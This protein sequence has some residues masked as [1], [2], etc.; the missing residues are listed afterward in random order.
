MTLD[1]LG[2]WASGGTPSRAVSAY[3]HGEI[4]WVKIGDLNDGVITRTAE[5]ITDSGLAASSARL[6]PPNVL[7]V[8]M[9]GASIGKLGVTGINCSTNQ[10]IASCVP[11]PDVVDLW[12]LY[13]ALRDAKDILISEGKGGAQPNISQTMLRGFEIP[14]RPWPSNDAS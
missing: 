5:T 2:D 3:Y 1:Q 6:L 10:A 14:L 11:N 8:A 12:Y 13:W 7:L 4:P 9:Y